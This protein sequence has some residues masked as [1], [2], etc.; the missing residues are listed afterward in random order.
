[1]SI[2]HMAY[3]WD[4]VMVGGSELLVMLAIAD[5]ADRE[6]GEAFPSVPFVASKCRLSERQTARIIKTLVDDGD[7]ELIK[8]GG[9]RRSNVYKIN[10]EN[11]PCQNVTPVTDDTPPLTPVTGHPPHLCQGNH[12]ISVIDPSSDDDDKPSYIGMDDEFRKCIG[13]WERN[14]NPTLVKAPLTMRAA[15]DDFGTEKVL[16]SIA[17]CVASEPKYPG[18]YIDAIWANWNCDGYDGDVLE[19]I[20]DR[21]QQTFIDPNT[22]ERLEL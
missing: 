21:E 11:D 12:H 8:R 5:S 22:G 2:K 17:R 4:S 7:L 10:T 18:A 1:M 3:V 14:Y 20:D 9:G 15:H 13:E 6:T 19:S 16:E